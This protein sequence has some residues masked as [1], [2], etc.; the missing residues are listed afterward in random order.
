MSCGFVFDDLALLLVSDLAFVL[1][2][3]HF[4]VFSLACFFSFVDVVYII[5]A[6]RCKPIM[7]VSSNCI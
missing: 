1:L 2:V 5:C 4:Y 3:W 6:S 7:E